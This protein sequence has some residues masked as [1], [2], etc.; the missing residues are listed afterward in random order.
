MVQCTVSVLW[1]Q[2][3]NPRGQS[4]RESHAYSMTRRLVS[5]LQS[6][7]SRLRLPWLLH[8]LNPVVIV[9]RKI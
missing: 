7:E 6:N 3:V 5:G 2:F 9:S 8:D 4:A 1:G